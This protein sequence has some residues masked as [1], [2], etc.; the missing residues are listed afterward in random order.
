M[1]QIFYR[2]IRSEK[3]KTLDAAKVG[4]WVI[5][6]APSHTELQDLA[7][8]Y[9]LDHSL[10]L[11]GVDV[12]ESPRIENEAG[13]T[14]LYT[15]FVYTDNN[16]IHTA[17]ILIVYAKQHLITI[18]PKPFPGLDK[19]TQGRLALV[20]TQKTK[21]LLQILTEV[22]NSYTHNLNAI[23]KT[24]FQIRA[25]LKKESISNQDFI[26][27]IDIEET[28]GDFLSG[29]VPTASVLRGLLSGR[30]VRLF[31]ED[32]DLIEDL[33]LGINELIE[34]TKSR[35]TTIQNIRNAYSTITANNLNRVIKMLTSLTIIITIPTIV[36]SIYGMNVTLPLMHK[37]YAFWFVVGVTAAAMLGAGWL[38]KRN[39][40]F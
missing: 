16:R 13:A 23:S 5:A 38:F 4:S 20:T 14:Y 32:E 39:K 24:I 22:L 27:F 30:Y 25:E 33:T 40:W 8:T 7:E 3:L 17:P 36:S 2:H 6:V 1:V 12:H 10:L 31:D 34:L 11:D 29:L 28:L 15:R 35:V 21:L 26:T 9:G 19:L 18:L 37:V